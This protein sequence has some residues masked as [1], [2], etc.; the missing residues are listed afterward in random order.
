MYLFSPYSVEREYG[1]PFAYL[2][3]TEKYDELVANP[4]IT[5]LAVK[6]P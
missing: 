2:D 4:N 6:A 5:T 3:I 1:T